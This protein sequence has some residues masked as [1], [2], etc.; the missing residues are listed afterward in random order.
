MAAI[1]G[2]T[3]EQIKELCNQQETV[4]AANYNSK[5]QIVISGTKKGVTVAIEKAKKIGI[6]RS[7]MLDV[8]GAFHSPLMKYARKKLQ[9]IIDNTEF[10]NPKI[11]IYQNVDPHPIKNSEKIKLNLINQLENAVKWSAT[12][13]N[14]NKNNLNYFIEVGPGKVLCN[15]NKR[16]NNNSV[17]K[18]FKDVISYSNV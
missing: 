15:L 7:I 13:L 12:I 1:I 14:M 18:S 4:V 3:T 17:N 6:K 16:I 9:H 10:Q 5:T 8:S 11:P 2:A